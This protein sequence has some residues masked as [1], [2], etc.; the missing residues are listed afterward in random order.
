VEAKMMIK[1]IQ[2]SILTS[3]PSVKK[4][5]I[6]RASATHIEQ[7]VEGKR[8]DR[9]TQP[10]SQGNSFGSV[11]LAS[12][13]MVRGGNIIGIRPQEDGNKIQRG[14]ATSADFSQ[15]YPSQA[16]SHVMV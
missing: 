15:V 9:P 11:Q 7:G 16:T 13:R 6:D 12:R 1:K 14:V 8:Q 3:K 2:D 4:M 10:L 5:A